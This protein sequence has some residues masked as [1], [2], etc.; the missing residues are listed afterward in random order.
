LALLAD[1]RFDGM[2]WAMHILIYK[3]MKPERSAALAGYIYDRTPLRRGYAND[4]KGKTL[5]TGAGS[6]AEGS[7]GPRARSCTIIFYCKISSDMLQ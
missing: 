3:A 7:E 2:A 4:F 1:H 6:L 5:C